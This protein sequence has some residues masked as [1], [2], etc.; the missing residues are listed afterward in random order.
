[1]REAAAVALAET[2][3]AWKIA[4]RHRDPLALMV[5]PE[6][7][8][9]AICT[10]A[11]DHVPLALAA[12]E[13]GRHVFVEKPLALALAEAD[14]LV[15]SADASAAK[16]LVGFNLRWPRLA[17]RAREIVRG[18]GIGR[19]RAVRSVFADPLLS[20]PGLPAWRLRRAQG[21]GSLLDKGIH[22]FDLWRYL[23]GEEIETVTAAS[24]SA[25]GD[26]EVALV[27]A[28]SSGGTLLSALVADATG[29]GNEMTLYGDAGTLHLDFYRSDGLE[30][31]PPAELSGAPLTRLRRLAASL[32][33]LARG[34]G[35]LARGG[36]FDAAYDRQWRH[37]AD[38][39][40]RDLR[41]GCDARDGR[42]AL[43][44][45]L[46]ALA[47]APDRKEAPHGD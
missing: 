45:A 21:G 7:E 9:V 15:A 35:E 19:V 13:A 43:A 39:V 1:M 41:S 23:L 38:I 17:L 25:T 10:P 36:A 37:F 34:A 47:D 8:A 33:A 2:G 24:D 20:Q 26:D 31:R 4:R 3:D 11:A 42:E 22:H 6:V 14:R 29:G 32:G 5:D 46:A 40:R 12:L 30:L 44:I 28:R 16:V 18:G 27:S